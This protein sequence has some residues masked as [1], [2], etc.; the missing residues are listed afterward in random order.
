MCRAKIL[1]CN[2]ISMHHLTS[3]RTHRWLWAAT[4]WVK[5]LHSQRSASPMAAVSYPCSEKEEKRRTESEK[6]LGSRPKIFWHNHDSAEVDVYLSSKCQ[7]SI[8][9]CVWVHINGVMN[10]NV[11]KTLRTTSENKVWENLPDLWCERTL[12][13]AVSTWMQKEKKTPCWLHLL[14]AHLLTGSLMVQM[15]W[16]TFSLPSLRCRWCFWR[17]QS[18]QT[19]SLWLQ[20]IQQ[21]RLFSKWRKNSTDSQNLTN[22]CAFLH[23]C[24]CEAKR[25]RGW[26]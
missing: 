10:R 20:T 9:K 4:M 5:K 1:Q 11:V 17:G 6:V 19:L 15:Q 23:P 13:G 8:H 22:V 3:K 26:S 21:E 25:H 18:A 12:T 2:Q 7:L 14:R 24:S 16:T